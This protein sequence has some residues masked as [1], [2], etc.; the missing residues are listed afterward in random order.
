[1]G[2]KCSKCGV[3]HASRRAERMADA[4]RHAKVKAG[5]VTLKVVWK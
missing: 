4:V 3:A 2:E 1:M 5:R